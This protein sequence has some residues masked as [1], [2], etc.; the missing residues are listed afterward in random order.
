VSFKRIYGSCLVISPWSSYQVIRY[1]WS[2]G[3]NIIGLGIGVAS[4]LAALFLN[5]KFPD[6]K[7]TRVTGKAIRRAVKIPIEV[8]RRYFVGS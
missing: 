4:P 3:G 5:S 6:I 2:Q 8:Q 1:F 7:P